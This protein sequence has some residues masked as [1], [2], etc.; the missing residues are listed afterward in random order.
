MNA[1]ALNR[2]AVNELRT[3]GEPMTRNSKAVNT[4]MGHRRRFPTGT[5]N[6]GRETGSLVET[7]DLI[8]KSS[9]RIAARQI[10]RAL[11]LT[12]PRRFR[13]KQSGACLCRSLLAA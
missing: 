8:T 13:A 6:R 4:Q 2:L 7:V 11:A 10:P 9:S 1:H 12:A 5:R 3:L